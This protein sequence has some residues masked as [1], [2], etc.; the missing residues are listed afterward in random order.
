MRKDLD[1]NEDIINILCEASPVLILNASQD[2]KIDVHKQLS[3]I[4]EQWEVLEANWIK[5]KTELEQTH[6]LAV[7]Y[8]SE[9]E[10]IEQWLADEES[11]F[12]N[13]SPPGTKVEVVKKQLRE[14]RVCIQL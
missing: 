8:Q 4:T 1:S 13:I 12:A 10:A 3:E 2:D 6:E 7:Q 11:V 5:R 9:L 14:M